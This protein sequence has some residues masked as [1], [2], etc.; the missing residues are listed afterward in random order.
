MS[1]PT[2][3]FKFNDLTEAKSLTTIVEQKFS[4]L[5]KFTSDTKSATC[6]VEFE[7]VAAHAQG[8]IYRVEANVVIEGLLY[9]AEATEESFE[10][11][12]DEVRS[13]LDKEMSRAKDKQVS[14]ERKVGREFKEHMLDGTADV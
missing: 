10:K 13:E 6:E 8:R 9:R 12:I 5:Q 2:I 11:A 14:L 7:V 1:F 4:S 3:V